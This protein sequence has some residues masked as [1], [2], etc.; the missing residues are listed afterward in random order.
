MKCS[1]L[2]Q[3]GK[4]QSNQQARKKMFF[5][6][7]FLLDISEISLYIFGPEKIMWH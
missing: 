6:V 2:I 5:L 3:E 4:A 1:Y 7:A